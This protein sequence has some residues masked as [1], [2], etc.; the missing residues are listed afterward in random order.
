MD[1]GGGAAGT[2]THGGQGAGSATTALSTGT[3][4][5]VQADMH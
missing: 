2:A 3:L 1:R 5:Q 4:A